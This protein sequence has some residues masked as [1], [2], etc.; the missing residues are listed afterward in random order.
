MYIGI[1][2]STGFSVLL[3]VLTVSEHVIALQLFCGPWEMKLWLTSLDFGSVQIFLS[4]EHLW[5]MEETC[6]SATAVF[7]LWY[8]GTDLPSL[9]G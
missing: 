9:A 5:Q 2:R 3:T 7:M 6:A 8:S 1:V 4:L